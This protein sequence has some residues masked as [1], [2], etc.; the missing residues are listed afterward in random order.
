MKYMFCN[1]SSL[2]KLDLSNFTANQIGD[3]SGMFKGCNSLEELDISNFQ[4]KKAQNV[5]TSYVFSGC[6]LLDDSI[7]IIKRVD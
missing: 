2:K 4:I 1:C 3:I 7:K 6:D 5:I